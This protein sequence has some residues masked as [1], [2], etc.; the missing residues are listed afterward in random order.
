MNRDVAFA[1]GT[2][3]VILSRLQFQGKVV[4]SLTGIA[5]ANW[6]HSTQIGGLSYQPP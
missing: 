3:Y 6:A 2:S 5:H 1:Q 4:G